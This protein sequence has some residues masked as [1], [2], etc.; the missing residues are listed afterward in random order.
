KAL[1]GADPQPADVVGPGGPGEFAEE[2]GEAA[3]AHAEL[4]GDAVEPGRLE[5]TVAEVGDVRLDGAAEVGPRLGL[6]AVRWIAGAAG[7][8]ESREQIEDVSGHHCG[9]GPL[10][11]GLRAP[12]PPR[13]VPHP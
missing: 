4:S 5:E 10:P 6:R 2:G 7:A 13:P 11:R 3:A 8:G 9:A 1:G 12:S